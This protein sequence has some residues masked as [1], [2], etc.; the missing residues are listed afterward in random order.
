MD[1]SLIFKFAETGRKSVSDQPELF[2]KD[3]IV[4][5]DSREI[6]QSFQKSHGDILRS[7]RLMIDIEPELAPHFSE[8]V[9]ERANPSGGKPLTFKAFHMDRIGYDTGRWTKIA[10]ANGTGQCP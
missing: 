2:V 4:L 3:G 6:A 7:I 10:R 8:F 5:A 1:I 9:V